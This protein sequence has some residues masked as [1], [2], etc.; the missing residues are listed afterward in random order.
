MEKEILPETWQDTRSSFRTFPVI[1]GLQ[2]WVVLAVLLSVCLHILVYVAIIELPLG[3]Y[4]TSESF[5]RA[6]DSKERERIQIS[7]DLLSEVEHLAAI[8]NLAPEPMVQAPDL[9]QIDAELDLFEAQENMPDKEVKLTPDVTDVTNFLKGEDD[10]MTAARPASTALIS[11]LEVTS[12]SGDS[13]LKEDIS[14]LSR[15]MLKSSAVSEDQLLLDVAMLD[16][17]TAPP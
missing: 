9:T 1:R 15:A 16:E 12:S 14:E 13:L 5:R 8:E 10:S 6:W 11:A 3:D 2:Q 7:P 17:G 4:L